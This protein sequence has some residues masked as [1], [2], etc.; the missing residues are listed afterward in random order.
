MYKSQPIPLKSKDCRC[1]LPLRFAILYDETSE[2]A[3][4]LLASCFLVCVI[5][6]PSARTN[7]GVK[8]G[9]ICL[10]L[11]MERYVENFL[12]SVLRPSGYVNMGTTST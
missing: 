12:S 9:R 4:L 7:Y 1:M 3:Q 11:L 10:P 6:L 2:M 8:H 5:V